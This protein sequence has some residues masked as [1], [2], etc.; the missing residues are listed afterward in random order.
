MVS[1]LPTPGNVGEMKTKPTQHAVRT[2]NA[3]G[4][5]PDILLARGETKIDEKRKSKLSLFC[6]ISADGIVSAPDV[7]SIYDIPI[8]FEKEKLSDKLCELMGVVCNKLDMKAWDAWK[9]FAK[10]AH[11]GKEAMK[12]AK[13][14]ACPSVVLTKVGRAGG[15]VV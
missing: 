4:I 15:G 12:I 2:L 1:Y 11:N 8:N 7:D 6:N 9:N 14:L 5:Q 10:H 3:S 13:A